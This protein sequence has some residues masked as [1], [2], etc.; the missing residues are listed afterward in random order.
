MRRT[1]REEA[2]TSGGLGAVCVELC[3]SRWNVSAARQRR[4]GQGLDRLLFEDHDEAQAAFN[5]EPEPEPKPTPT[6]KPKPK[7]KPRPKSPGLTLT[8]T[9]NPDPNPSQAAFEAGSMLQP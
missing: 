1:I 2:A 9:P 8:L 3:P 7:P 6:P 4:P 5:P